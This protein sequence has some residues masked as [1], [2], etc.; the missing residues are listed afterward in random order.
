[1]PAEVLRARL[2]LCHRLAQAL[3]LPAAEAAEAGDVNG[4]GYD[5]VIVGAFY[6]D[7]NGTNSGAAFI[8]KGSGLRWGSV[9]AQELNLQRGV[10]I[11]SLKLDKYRLKTL[12]NFEI[13]TANWKLSS[14]GTAQFQEL[15]VGGGNATDKN[16]I[17][18]YLGINTTCS[19][20]DIDCSGDFE[21]HTSRTR[22]Q[23]IIV[24]SKQR[25]RRHRDNY[26][27]C[28]S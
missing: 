5:D 14:A 20:A 10:E 26:A 16:Y 7:G 2:M 24:C 18:S 6:N 1:M 13:S 12:R 11:G 17:N 25:L 27:K 4:D 28:N 19:C 23:C 22:R 21:C 3:L 15:K 9:F 8:Y